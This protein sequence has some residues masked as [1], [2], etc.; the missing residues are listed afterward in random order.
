[1]SENIDEDDC[2]P[3]ELAQSPGCEVDR[4]DHEGR[5]RKSPSGYEGPGEGETRSIEDEE[6]EYRAKHRRSSDSDS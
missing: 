1:M 3:E 2:G 6:K 5:L 4:D